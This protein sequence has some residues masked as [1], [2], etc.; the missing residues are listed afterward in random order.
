[1]ERDFSERDRRTLYNILGPQK[2]EM[3]LRG[4]AK[5]S[6]DEVSYKNEGGMVNFS[7]NARGT[8]GPNWIEEFSKTGNRIRL[9][10]GVEEFLNSERFKVSNRGKLDVVILKGGL[11]V[12]KL[13]HTR[14]IIQSAEGQGLLK[15]NPDLAC[16]LAQSLTFADF[17][18]LGLKRIVVMHDP[19]DG[20]NPI[21]SLLCVD[22]F[23]G[24]EE[25]EAY[26]CWR[27]YDS[28]FSIK[29]NNLLWEV[30]DGFAFV[31]S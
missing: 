1:M 4:L 20:D 17:Q 16:I 21:D 27:F 12:D 31:K 18:N 2:T 29:G 19:Q 28:I 3:I 8:S 23:S 22:P 7:V 15:P 11:F 30:T 9:S 13:R 14:K 26:K 6:Y 24:Y 5:V 10:D 25:D